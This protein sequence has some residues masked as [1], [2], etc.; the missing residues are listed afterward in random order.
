MN[1][2]VI[3]WRYDSSKDNYYTSTRYVAKLTQKDIKL[4]KATTLRLA[5]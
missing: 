5:I 4:S 3:D 2:C 1:I